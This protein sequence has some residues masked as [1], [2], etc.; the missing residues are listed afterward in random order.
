MSGSNVTVY[1]RNCS[2]PNELRGR[3]MTLALT[4]R[5]CGIY[6]C[7]GEWEKDVVKFNFKA[8]PHIPIGSKGR[9]ENFLYEVV[10]FVVKEEQKYRYR[11]REYLLFNPY[12]GYA[13]LAESDGH[14]NF[15]WPIEGQPK[16]DNITKNFFYE[17]REFK[18]YQK[19]AATVI[20]AEGEFFFDV[21]GISEN[22]VNRDY[23]SP[24]YLLTV[25]ESRDSVL[26]CKGEYFFQKDIA[27]I[28]SIP[29]QKL[30]EKEGIGY[31]QPFDMGVKTSVL[32]GCAV[33]FIAILI[34]F[35]VLIDSVSEEKVVYHGQYSQADMKDQKMFVTPSFQLSEGKSSV[36]FYIEAPL[37]NDWFYGEFTLVNED[38][39]TEYNFSKEIE[40]YH[41]YEG[42]ESW[43]EGAK[44]GTAYISQIP[45]GKYHVNIYPEFSM[46][47]NSF[48]IIIT[49]DVPTMANFWITALLIIAFPAFFLI[50]NHY[51]EVRRWSDSDY[52]PYSE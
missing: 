17:G 3:A 25:E 29:A 43:S 33:L 35:Q 6:F 48:S 41:G 51:R 4:C 18:L 22:T 50:R 2:K 10:G 8:T 47:N 37:S 15:V 1:C 34:I 7:T 11:W 45:G 19:Y 16:G 44:V 32:V 12:R 27:E 26:W 36:E 42:G 40:F 21:V 13:F 30:P 39:G 31:T 20:Y 52:S 14:W 5:E 38:D 24:P 9:V 49:R 23:I 46:F 28:F